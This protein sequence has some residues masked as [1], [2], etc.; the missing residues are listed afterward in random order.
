MLIL[1]AFHYKVPKGYIY[2]AVFFSLFVEL[3]NLKV[4]KSINKEEKTKKR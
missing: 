4:R 3:I 2:F 1:D